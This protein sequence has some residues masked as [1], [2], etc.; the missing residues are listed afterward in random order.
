MTVA[1]NGKQVEQF[2]PPANIGETHKYA[3]PTPTATPKKREPRQ[4]CKRFGRFFDPRCQ[5]VTPSPGPTCDPNGGGF[6]QQP[7]P[8]PSPT[9]NDRCDEFP[10]FPGCEPEEGGG[11]GG[12]DTT[13]QQQSQPVARTEE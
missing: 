7:C 13:T 8:T 5:E 9:P 12:D 10:N 1:M 4:D 6:A 3:T 11:G 2:P